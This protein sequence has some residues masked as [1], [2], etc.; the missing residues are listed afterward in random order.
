MTIDF[1][2]CLSKKRRTDIQIIKILQILN[3]KRDKR[4]L[5]ESIFPFSLV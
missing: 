2:W 3:S 5:F 1:Y 4:V